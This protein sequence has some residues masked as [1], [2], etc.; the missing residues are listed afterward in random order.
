[1]EFE[2]FLAFLDIEHHLGL[3]GRDKWSR[4]GNESQVLVKWLVGQ[5]LVERT[6]SVLPQL[7]YDFASELKPGDVILTFNNDVILEH[8]LE[9]VERAYR[10]FQSRNS[11]SVRT[12]EPEKDVIVLKL[13]GSVDWFDKTTY[14]QIEE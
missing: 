4:E 13:H 8:T 14:S 3:A 11:V 1:M 12:Y 9:R 5:I 7:Y 6:P 2:D 10:L